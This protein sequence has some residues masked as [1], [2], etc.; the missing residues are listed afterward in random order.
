MRI[1]FQADV[2]LKHA[3][4]TGTLRRAGT[5]DFQRAATVHLDGLDDPTVLA[6]AAQAGRVLVSHD[7]NSMERHFREFIQTRRSPG[8]V[9]VPQS[10]VSVGKAVEGLL[11][12]WEVLDSGDLENRVCLLP[13]LAI[14]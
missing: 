4:V 3:I 2:D 12:I 1:R 8:L 14:S 5:V 10:G 6:I 11:L 13:S 7:V 9:L